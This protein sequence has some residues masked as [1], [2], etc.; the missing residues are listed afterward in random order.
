MAEAEDTR[1]GEERKA[2]EERRSANRGEARG[3][4]EPIGED[5]CIYPVVEEKSAQKEP[6][7][8]ASCG[9]VDKEGNVESIPVFTFIENKDISPI[10]PAPAPQNLEEQPPLQDLQR[11]GTCRLGEMRSLAPVPSSTIYDQSRSRSPT[12]RP[13]SSYPGMLSNFNNS[14]IPDGRSL[15]TPPG[16]PQRWP[17]NLVINQPRGNLD[18]DPT[19]GGS[20]PSS[21]QSMFEERDEQR[22]NGSYAYSRSNSSPVPQRPRAYS[23]LESSEVGGV[24]PQLAAGMVPTSDGEMIQAEPI[25]RLVCKEID[26]VH[27][28]MLVS[29]PTSDEMGCLITLKAASGSS[30]LALDHSGLQ[31]ASKSGSEAATIMSARQCALFRRGLALELE[32]VNHQIYMKNVQIRRFQ[33]LREDF[34]VH[35]GTLKPDGSLNRPVLLRR[36]RHIINDMYSHE[37]R[38][39]HKWMEDDDNFDNHYYVILASAA[40]ARPLTSSFLQNSNRQSP[41]STPSKSR[42][43]NNR[44]TSPYL[45]HRSQELSQVQQQLQELDIQV[46]RHLQM[47]EQSDSRQASDVMGRTPELEQASFSTGLPSPRSGPLVPRGFRSRSP[48]RRSKSP[49]ERLPEM[50]DGN[51]SH[52]TSSRGRYS[53]RFS[54]N[55]FFPFD[56]TPSSSTAGSG[57]MGLPLGGA[58]FSVL[59]MVPRPSHRPPDFCV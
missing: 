21:Q 53:P 19:R 52:A 33:I 46:A 25:E 31:L 12:Q 20:Q 44:S 7:V 29:H 10:F 2:G 58:S 26:P 28:C 47:L 36:Y 45:D 48:Y 23:D 15:P 17:P 24:D 22:N 34:S 5:R 42:Q 39:P 38:Y 40:A 57:F 1:T 54:A 18:L 43:V 51:E 30:G 27:F 41:L 56:K 35:N 4:S 49:R 32:F 50:P 14:K 9:F 59:E 13:I 37:A 8:Q 6:S 16:E 3:R 55:N 11:E